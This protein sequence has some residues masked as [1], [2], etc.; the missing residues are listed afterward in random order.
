MKPKIAF[1]EQSIP[2]ILEALG[3]EID[4]FG[5]VVKDGHFVYDLDKNIVESK[6]IIGIYKDIFLTKDSHLFK[7][8]RLLK[9]ND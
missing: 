1:D 3:Y 6:A 8:V 4:H 2:F 9:P 5:F 7:L